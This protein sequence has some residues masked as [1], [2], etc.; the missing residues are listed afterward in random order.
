MK[1]ASVAKGRQDAMKASSLSG[2]F[3]GGGA[4]QN[5]FPSNF[6]PICSSA[7][8]SSFRTTTDVPLMQG[9]KTKTKSFQCQ[10]PAA[11][12]MHKVRYLLPDGCSPQL[13]S[14]LEDSDLPFFRC[15]KEQ[16]SFYGMDAI[17]AINCQNIETLRRWHQK[18]RPLETSNEVGKSLIHLA[19]KRG[20]LD[21]VKFLVQEACVSLWVH[22][23]KGRTPFHLLCHSAGLTV[24][25][26]FEFIMKQDIDLL[27]VTDERGLMP[28]D[29]VPCEMWHEWILFLES[30]NPRDFIPNREIF[31]SRRTLQNPVLFSSKTQKLE[32]G[33]Q[34]KWSF[35]KIEDDLLSER[36]NSDLENDK[37]RSSVLNDG[38]I[39]L[40]KEIQWNNKK[41]FGCNVTNNVTNSMHGQMSPSMGQSCTLQKFTDKSI[42]K[43]DFCKEDNV[44]N[45]VTNSMHGQMSPSMG[46]SCT[47]QKFTDKSIGKP[48]FCKEDGS[49]INFQNQT[50]AKG[51]ISTFEDRGKTREDP[52][53]LTEQFPLDNDACRMRD[54][55]NND[56][57]LIRAPFG[58]F[59]KG[60]TVKSEL[61]THTSDSIVLDRVYC[62]CNKSRDSS[63]D[64]HLQLQLAITHS[65]ELSPRGYTKVFKSVV[66][67]LRRTQ[68]TA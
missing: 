45:N 61:E 53:S 62:V 33:L 59:C 3:A 50:L 41:L 46:Q 31:L 28:L 17:N 54:Q 34:K 48:D 21:V 39:A 30:L 18:G 37:N 23:K 49:A 20:S 9:D 29:N 56:E 67:K 8:S 24:F 26:L 52:F 43:P 55:P 12:I 63:Q 14:A 40:G 13:I 44:T 64:C 58:N 27:Y 38:D 57:E 35:G 19:C 51:S 60:C 36:S 65:N 42:G 32:E 1:V 25:Q 7:Q 15:P 22:D 4:Q 2:R 5:I 11:Y 10:S 66:S 6:L 68:S 47:L 16:R